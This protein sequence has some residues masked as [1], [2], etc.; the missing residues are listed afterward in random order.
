MPFVSVA[1][2]S[3]TFDDEHSTH[4]ALADFVEQCFES[5]SMDVSACRPSLVIV[6]DADMIPAKLSGTIG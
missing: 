5:A 2:K 3:C 4:L 1:S 6:N